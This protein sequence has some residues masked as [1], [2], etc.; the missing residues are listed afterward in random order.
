MQREESDRRGQDLL[1]D[2]VGVGEQFR[3]KPPD[4]GTGTDEEACVAS[5]PMLWR[6][7]DG[8]LVRDVP[9]T[10]AIMPYLMRGRNESAVYFEQQVAMRH[11]D[12]FV[13]EFNVAHPE[14]PIT[15]STS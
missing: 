8:D 10:K 11:A 12:A 15:S 1:F 14:T 5:A 2:H 7:P 6:R 4:D 3:R 9:P 13:R